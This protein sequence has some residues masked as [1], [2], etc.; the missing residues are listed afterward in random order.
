M[1]TRRQIISADTPAPLLFVFSQTSLLNRHILPQV[2]LF[3][4]FQPAL[5]KIMVVPAAGSWEVTQRPGGSL[6]ARSPAGRAGG[7]E[8]AGPWALG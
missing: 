3:E 7:Q 1:A 8:S 5:M 4:Y 2:S 6:P